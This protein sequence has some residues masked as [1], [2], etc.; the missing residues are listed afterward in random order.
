MRLNRFSGWRTRARIAQVQAKL[1]NFYSVWPEARQKIPTTLMLEMRITP[2]LPG[3][4]D[5]V[6]EIFFQLMDGK[7]TTEEE[8]RAFL[9]PHSPPA[10]PPPVNIRRTRA[11]K[12]AKIE[13]DDHDDHEDDADHDD[14]E[15][16]DEDDEAAIKLA[17]AKKAVAAKAAKNEAAGAKSAPAEASGKSEKA[18]AR[19]GCS[20][21]EN[22]CRGACENRC[23]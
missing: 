16:E 19:E 17:P 14:H 11:K 9:E 20:A 3:Y 4:Q 5:L 23:G 10:P 1:K 21:R 22:C 6:Q 7:L 12:A 8:M 15:D 13:A 2:D 18:A